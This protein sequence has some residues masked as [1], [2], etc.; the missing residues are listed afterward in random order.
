MHVLV[1]TSCDSLSVSPVSPPRAY[2]S[3]SSH[4][5][6]SDCV[7]VDGDTHPVSTVACRSWHIRTASVSTSGDTDIKLV[8]VFNV[9]RI[10]SNCS[11]FIPNV[12]SSYILQSLPAEYTRVKSKIKI[13]TLQVRGAY[14]ALVRNIRGYL[15]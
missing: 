3:V 4:M 6:Q 8:P 5:A 15:R 10:I 13:S 2:C 12:F 14:Y 11:I 7:C 1:L 9:L